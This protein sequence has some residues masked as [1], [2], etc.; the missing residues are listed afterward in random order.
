MDEN[1][2]EASESITTGEQSTE[3]AAPSAPDYVTADQLQD[4]Q[5]G[6]MGDMRK[7]IAGMLKTQPTQQQQAKP[8]TATKSDVDV[9]AMMK[10][11]QQSERALAKHGF[12]DGQSDIAR[13]MIDSQNPEDVSAFIGDLAKQMGIQPA[14]SPAQSATPAPKP[15][16]SSDGGSPGMTS[17]IESDDQ[18]VWKWSEEKTAKFI[19]EKGMREFAKVMKNR[20]RGDLQG[21]RFSFP[22]S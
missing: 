6:L 10:A 22:R 17:T 11:Y 5:K 2:S 21:Q 18:P 12:S 15:N 20:L 14:N 8:E 1:N 9:P 3:A 7:T 16:P 19:K 4:F 13:A